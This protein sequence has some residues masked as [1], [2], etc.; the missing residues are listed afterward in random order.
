MAG[1]LRTG[2]GLRLP[3]VWCMC[4]IWAAALTPMFLTSLDNVGCWRGH[5]CC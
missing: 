2:A 1:V 4:A 5:D 3:C